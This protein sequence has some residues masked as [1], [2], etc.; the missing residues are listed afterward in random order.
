MLP[1][2]GAAGLIRV[3]LVGDSIIDGVGASSGLNTVAPQ[4]MAVA[5]G[6]NVHTLTLP[7]TS[8][9]FFPGANVRAFL[10][11]APV[12]VYVV[13]FLGTNDFGGAGSPLYTRLPH[14]ANLMDRHL[15]AALK[16]VTVHGFC[17]TPIPRSDEPGANGGGWTLDQYR[18][19]IAERCR[20][21]G[22]DV[23]DGR[24]LGLDLRADYADGVHLNDSGQ[25]KLAKA[26]AKHLAT[27]IK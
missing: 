12:P 11:F 7:R 23:L 27:I 17:V 21:H 24:T 6:W 15:N 2:A 22:L 18:T 20:A 25:R 10:T 26:I 1:D 19:V 13:Y 8:W 16:S 5:P 9:R 14:L 3:V 4:I